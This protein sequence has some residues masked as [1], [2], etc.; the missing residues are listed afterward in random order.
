MS[1]TEGGWPKDVDC[2]EAE[3][4][5]RFRRKVE[6]DED[7][8]RSIVS[9]GC[10]ARAGQES[11]PLRTAFRVDCSLARRLQV[12]SLIK[13]NNAIDIYE[14]Y[15]A[16]S[17][18]EHAS[19]MSH[20]R[21]LTVFRDPSPV[22]RAASYVSWFPDGARKVAVAYSIMHFQQQP[23]GMPCSRRAKKPPP[24]PRLPADACA[25]SSGT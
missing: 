19:E 20:A 11:A 14:D 6:K 7:Y 24:P 3:H 18:V 1:H 13:E 21:T 10:Q 2:T 5:I 15:F 9:L 25:A 23:E 12:E 22:T 16:G 17:L 4:V 8:I